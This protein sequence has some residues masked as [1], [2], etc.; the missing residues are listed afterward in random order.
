MLFR[1]L[2]NWSLNTGVGYTTALSFGNVQGGWG[3][4]S[5]S[6][7]MGRQLVK[8]LSFVSGFTASSYRSNAFAAYNRV[9]YSVVVGLGY[10]SRNIPIRFF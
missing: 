4:V 1:S 7:G 5:G 3:Q 9:I 6:F 10:S 2:R 8:S